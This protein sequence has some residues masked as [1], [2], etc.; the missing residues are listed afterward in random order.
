MHVFFIEEK[1][2][3]VSIQQTTSSKVLTMSRQQ[4]ISVRKTS[5]NN[6]IRFTVTFRGI[7]FRTSSN[8]T[9][10]IPPYIVAIKRK[11]VPEERSN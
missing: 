6:K 7:F 3:C 10:S 1:N 11:A 8:N 9:P 5:K 2:L 4:V